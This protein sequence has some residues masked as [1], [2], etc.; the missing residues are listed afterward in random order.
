MFIQYG[1]L[2]VHAKY[3]DRGTVFLSWVQMLREFCM[4][5]EY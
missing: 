1:L 4:V 3:G 2:L 5:A